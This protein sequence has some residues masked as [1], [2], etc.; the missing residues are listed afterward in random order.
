VLAIYVVFDQFMTV[1][2]PPTIL[3]KFFPAL[4]AFVPSL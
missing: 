2:W 1:P 4:K 3:G